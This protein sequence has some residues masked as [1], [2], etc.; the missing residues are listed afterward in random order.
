[1][2]RFYASSTALQVIAHFEGVRLMAYRCPADI[3]TIGYGHTGALIGKPVHA[4]TRI[5]LE[6]ARALLEADIAIVEKGVNRLIIGSPTTQAQFDALVSFAFNLGLPALE[7]SSLLKAHKAQN[8][9]AASRQFARWVYANGVALK[10]LQ[11]RRALEALLYLGRVAQ[12]L[13]LA[14]WPPPS[15]IEML[16]TPPLRTQTPPKTRAESAASMQKADAEPARSAP[17][18]TTPLN[19]Q[20]LSGV[21]IDTPEFD[22]PEFDT[23]EEGAS[24]VETALEQT[25]LQ[26][27]SAVRGATPLW[28]AVYSQSL[29]TEPAPALSPAPSPA[30]ANHKAA[31]K[32]PLYSLTVQGLLL[33]LLGQLGV[34]TA[35]ELAELTG[36]IDQT[37]MGF[38][39][40][41]S[42]AGLVLAAYGRWRAQGP[43]LGPQVSPQLSPQLGRHNKPHTKTHRF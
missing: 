39:A 4:H 22:T 14:P 8:H 12:V 15:T 29:L 33:S 10:G 23:A 20:A 42:L 13:S 19:T 30:P 37:I 17:A 32:S 16:T 40:A 18:T 36:L 11:R 31:P 41:L 34:L 6:E 1:M 24:L 7:Q 5:S 3:W 21:A 25:P 35:S 27:P 9:Q 28:Q 38:H 26:G 43:L 2:P